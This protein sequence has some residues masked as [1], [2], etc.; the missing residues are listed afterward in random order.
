M[1]V[2]ACHTKKHNNMK[3]VIIA[4][5]TAIAV[6]C[7]AMVQPAKAGGVYD[8]VAPGSSILGVRLGLSGI[9]GANVTYDYSL[10]RVWKGTFTIGGD[11]GYMWG[12]RGYVHRV[13]GTRVGERGSNNYVNIRIRTTYR[14]NVVVPEWEVYAGV[15][16]GGG[17]NAWRD[18][19]DPHGE[20][21]TITG[22]YGFCSGAFILG[23]SYWFTDAISANL[24]FDF[25]NLSQSYVNLGV[26][27]KF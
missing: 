24:E 21:L 3:K 27:F 20:V 22:T 17:F 19:T 16:L 7:M 13:D 25:G 11:I 4:L 18:Y 10:A 2:L 23:T 9:V 14:L 26:N 1:P 5:V 8:G 12:Q 6:G 15:A